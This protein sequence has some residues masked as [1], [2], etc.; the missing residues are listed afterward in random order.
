MDL[1]VSSN[2]FIILSGV[3]NVQKW[4]LS[5]ET[6]SKVNAKNHNRFALSLLFDSEWSPL[7]V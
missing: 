4:N 3:F 5:T 2:C 1:L 7:E 6:A